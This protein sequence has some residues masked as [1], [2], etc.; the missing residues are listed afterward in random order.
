MSLLFVKNSTQ[1]QC[2]K[3]WLFGSKQDS[4][5]AVEKYQQLMFADNNSI[6]EEECKQMI[7]KMFKPKGVVSIALETLKN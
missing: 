3:Q 4:F 6:L 2:P 5:E 1:N 7:D